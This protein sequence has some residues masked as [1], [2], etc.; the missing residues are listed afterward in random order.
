MCG[1]RAAPRRPSPRRGPPASVAAA[2]G[3]ARPGWVPAARLAVQR[4]PEM[5]DGDQDVVI[6]SLGRLNAQAEAR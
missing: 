5:T 6:H 2:G 4:A 3:G 1:E